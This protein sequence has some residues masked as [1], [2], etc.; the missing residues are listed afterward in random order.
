M[1]S[2]KAHPSLLM[3]LL[4]AT[5]PAEGDDVRMLGAQ[6]N[7]ATAGI[8]EHERHVVL[9]VHMEN[10][11]HQSVNEDL[12]AFLNISGFAQNGIQGPTTSYMSPR[13]SQMTQQRGVRTTAFFQGVGKDR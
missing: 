7:V 4:S 8:T 12:V 13:P 2:A 5:C 6:R 1:Q 10:E 11:F 3:R 9:R